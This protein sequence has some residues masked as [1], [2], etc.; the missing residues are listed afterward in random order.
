MGNERRVLDVEV[1]L[2]DLLGRQLTLVSDRLGGE[3]VDVKA[4]LGAEHGRGLLLGHL[5]YTE[6][7]TFKV[8]R[9][10]PLGT[11]VSDKELRC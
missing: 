3:G 7:F 2:G 5:A 10:E 11:A 8:T 4:T 1:I 6:E 9:R